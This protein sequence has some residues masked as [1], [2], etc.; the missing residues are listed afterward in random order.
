[1]VNLNSSVQGFHDNVRVGL[2]CPLLF[3]ITV[4]TIQSRGH[5]V[6]YCVVYLMKNLFGLIKNKLGH[7]CNDYD[8][9]MN[10]HDY[11]CPVSLSS[12]SHFG[13]HLTML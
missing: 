13:R 2:L 1:M 6:L 10:T 12:Y 9:I 8:I 3:H 7:K 5:S 4:L 11:P